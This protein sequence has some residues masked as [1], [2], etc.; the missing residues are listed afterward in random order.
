MLLYF[1]KSYGFAVFS[2]GS[3]LEFFREAKPSSESF[4]LMLSGV[5]DVLLLFCLE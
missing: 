5:C 2:E 4:L 3:Q 1:L